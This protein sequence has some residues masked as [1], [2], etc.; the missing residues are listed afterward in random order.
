MC[1]TEL[2]NS[3]N[4]VVHFESVHNIRT[5]YIFGDEHISWLRLTSANITIRKLST[6]LDQRTNHK[7]QESAK[8]NYDDS[9]KVIAANNAIHGYLNLQLAEV[10][11]LNPKRYPGTTTNV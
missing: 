5:E 2:F 11:E 3:V 7:S 1:L 4:R 6:L 10:S 9:S 8:L